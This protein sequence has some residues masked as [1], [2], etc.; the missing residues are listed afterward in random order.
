MSSLVKVTGVDEDPPRIGQRQQQP[1][2]PR[3]QIGNRNPENG[4]ARHFHQ[5]EE[6][7][8]SHS[9]LHANA[10]IIQVQPSRFGTQSYHDEYEEELHM[11]VQR[12]P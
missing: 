2:L 1:R 8:I 4:A 5:Q 7:K 10:N 3:I 9:Q 11:K 12:P 6:Q